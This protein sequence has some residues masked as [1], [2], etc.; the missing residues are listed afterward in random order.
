MPIWINAVG[1]GCI[2]IVCGYLLFYWFKRR[3]PPSAEVPLPLNE[4]V[5]LLAT[6]GAGGILGGAF[7]KLEGVNYIGAYGI[8]LLC[9]LA[10]NVM[11]TMLHEAPFGAKRGGIVPL[12][13]QQESVK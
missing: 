13:R 11:L 9:G 2:G 6:I 5:T 7:I 8:G 3:H 12:R 1:I 4:V 10:T